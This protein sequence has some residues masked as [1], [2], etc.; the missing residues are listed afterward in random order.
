MIVIKGFQNR[1]LVGNGRLGLRVRDVR[2][3]NSVNKKTCNEYS[4]YTCKQFVWRAARPVNTTDCM[5][6]WSYFLKYNR[7]TSM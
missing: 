3:G 1:E 7:N 2:V 6:E 4:T 5:N